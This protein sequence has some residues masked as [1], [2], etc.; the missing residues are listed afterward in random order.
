MATLL[1]VRH[2]APS[3][4]RPARPKSSTLVRRSFVTRTLSGFRSR[5]ITARAD[6]LEDDEPLEP[7]Q[8]QLRGDRGPGRFR[9]RLRARRRDARFAMD[10]E[11]DTAMPATRQRSLDEQTDVAADVA[12]RTALDGAFLPE[13][14]LRLGGDWIRHVG[15]CGLAGLRRKFSVN[16]SAPTATSP[17]PFTSTS[18]STWTSTWT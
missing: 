3:A 7:R 14:R 4:C 1:C 11:S 16:C 10:L 2:W 13:R 6:P 5:W 15:Q 17:S 8:R 9:G 18:T 12:V